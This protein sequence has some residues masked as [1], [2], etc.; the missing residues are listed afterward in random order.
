[1]KKLLILP[2]ILLGCSKSE[3]SKCTEQNTNTN[4]IIISCKTLRK[5]SSSCNSRS[6]SSSTI[7]QNEVCSLGFD[8]NCSPAKIDPPA[9]KPSLDN[10][11]IVLRNKATGLKLNLKQVT[12]GSD[13]FLIL[14]QE[15]DIGETSS[16]TLPICSS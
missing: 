4:E 7:S 3:N 10:G 11:T 2:L 15:G 6:V 9:I 12:S 14:Q 13:T 16:V 8:L 1:M 5:E